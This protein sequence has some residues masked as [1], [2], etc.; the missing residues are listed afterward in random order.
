MEI[1]KNG[2]KI[3]IADLVL[4]QRHIR[5]NTLYMYVQFG[6]DEKLYIEVIS[7]RSG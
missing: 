6:V 3:K 7:V 2:T 4:M 1:F 5:G